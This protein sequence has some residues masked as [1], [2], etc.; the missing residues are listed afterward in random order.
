MHHLYSHSGSHRVGS[1]MDVPS[2]DKFYI[3]LLPD[4]MAIQLANILELV[5]HKHKGR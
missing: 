2:I 5:K 3:Y 1:Q 4:H